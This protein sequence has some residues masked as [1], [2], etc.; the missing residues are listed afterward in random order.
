M[1]AFERALQQALQNK[2][3]ASPETLAKLYAIADEAPAHGGHMRKRW[4]ASGG[5]KVL[6]FPKPRAWMGGA[7]AAALVIG[8]FTAEQ[9]HDRRER[10]AVADQQFET[11]THIEDMAL[12]HTREQLARKGI[13]L[14]Q[15]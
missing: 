14:D 1:D 5:G 10:R 12:Q 9:V 8:V 15:Q 4:F 2:V 6:V 3:S 13:L 7:L 11:A